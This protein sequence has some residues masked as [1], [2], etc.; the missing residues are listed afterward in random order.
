MVEEVATIP[1]NTIKFGRLSIA[2]LEY[3]LSCTHEKEKFFVTQEYE[4]YILFII[5]NYFSK[6]MNEIAVM[7]I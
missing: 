1:L 4:V 2:G 5:I 6:Q 3:L 7:L